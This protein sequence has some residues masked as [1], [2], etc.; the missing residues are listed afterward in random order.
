M[1]RNLLAALVVLVALASSGEAKCINKTQF[2]QLG[3][4]QGWSLHLMSPAQV[5]NAVKLYNGLPD[6]NLKPGDYDGA[7]LA[8]HDGVPMVKVL[9]FKGKCMVGKILNVPGVMLNELM[10]RDS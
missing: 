6:D 2:L 8:E 9:F 3:V 7:V 4:K 5:A 1:I 10:G